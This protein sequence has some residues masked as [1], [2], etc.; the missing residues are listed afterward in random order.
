MYNG[1]VKVGAGLIHRL[2][3]K[4]DI[5]N[6][7]HGGIVMFTVVAIALG[8]ISLGGFTFASA[9]SASGAEQDLTDWVS[10]SS[11]AMLAPALAYATPALGN[12][13]L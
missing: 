6:R 8:F 9:A 12:L 2:P 13:F 11:F 1:T 10:A 4:D 5:T 3:T 7:D